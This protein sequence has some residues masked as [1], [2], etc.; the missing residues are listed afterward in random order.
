MTRKSMFFSLGV[1]LS[2]LVAS[3]ASQRAKFD[4][5]LPG[6]TSSEVRKTMEGGPSKIE[7][8]TEASYTSWYWGKDYCVLFKDNQVMSKDSTQSGR[9]LK[10]G[11]G[12][13]AEKSLA[14]CIPPNETAKNRTERSVN[15]PGF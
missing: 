3:C 2:A 4:D 15:L 6:M 11:P 1:I 14:Q 13:Y 5:I 9:K 10:V 12:Q 7:S 8:G